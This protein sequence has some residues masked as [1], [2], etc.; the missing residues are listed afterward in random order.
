MKQIF[1]IF[2]LIALPILTN[3]AAGVTPPSD[4]LRMTGTTICNNGPDVY[5]CLLHKIIF[6]TQNQQYVAVGDDYDAYRKPLTGRSPSLILISK[7]GSTN[8]QRANT[9]LK[10]GR[11]QRVIQGNNEL[12][13]IGAEDTILS[14]I[15]G[16]NWQKMPINRLRNSG[17]PTSEY[18]TITG[19]TYNKTNNQYLAIGSSDNGGAA[20][21]VNKNNKVWQ[22]VGSI[23]GFYGTL[24]QLIYNEVQHEYIAV[25]TEG[26]GR[27]VKVIFASTDGLNWSRIYNSPADSDGNIWEIT[28]IGTRQYVAVGVTLGNDGKAHPS[29]LTSDD[30]VQ[31]NEDN[32][33]LSNIWGELTAISWNGYKVV[34]VGPNYTTNK[35]LIVNS[36]DMINWTT[37]FTNFDRGYSCVMGI[38]W[39]GNKFVIAGDTIYSNPAYADVWTAPTIL[40]SSNG[41]DWTAPIGG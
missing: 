40:N 33:S 38:A 4:M 6:D 9:P 14:S 1:K 10:S 20:I 39:G 12:I 18:L 21:L 24:N 3:L 2:M 11:L 7:D 25:G 28:Q 31:W 32:D 36:Q 27:G 16:I 15:N 26:L 22:E 37:F 35:F 29:I 34:A 13:A 23:Y 8:W 17:A 30:G 19:V 41:I 5:N